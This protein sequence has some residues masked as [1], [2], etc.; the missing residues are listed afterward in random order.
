MRFR[1]IRNGID[2]LLNKYY[3]PLLC[4]LCFLLGLATGH[5]Y[6]PVNAVEVPYTLTELKTC[7]A[8]AV[9]HESRGEPKKG[10]KIVMDSVQ[11]RSADDHWRANNPC[12]VIYQKEQYSFTLHD[13]EVLDKRVAQDLPKYNLI[14]D[15]V[16]LN[17]N[18]PAVKGYEG[19]NHYLRCDIR[20]SVNHKWYANMKFLGQVGAHCFYKGY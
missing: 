17:W 16:E 14:Q 2:F 11:T 19:V 4:A 3:V 18:L 1:Q 13:K 12:D 10:W 5:R 15:F 6:D 8:Q 7:M 9:F 20:A